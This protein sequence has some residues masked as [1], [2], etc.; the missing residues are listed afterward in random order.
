VA[1][2]V[3][4]NQ[5][6]RRYGPRPSLSPQATVGDPDFV[7]PFQSSNDAL[8]YPEAPLENRPADWEPAE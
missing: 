6:A 4:A 8:G 2:L 1:E 5:I 7:S 3:R